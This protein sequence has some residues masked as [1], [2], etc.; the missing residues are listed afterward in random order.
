[1]V[2]MGNIWDR[3]AEFLSDNLGTVLPVALL[4]IFVPTVVSSNLSEL[5]QGAP[6]GLS[7][8]LG[9]ASLV[10]ALVTFWGQLTI[11]ALAIDPAQGRD[12]TRVATRR[13]LPALL[14]MIVLLGAALLTIIPLAII[15]AVGGMD[16]T[17]VQPGSMPE[18]PE[19]ARMPVAIYL[20]ILLPLSV[21]LFARLA[22]V[23]PVVVGEEKGVGAISR[24]WRLTRGM[25]LKIVGV[26]ILYVIVSLVATLAATTAFGT[27]MGL[28]AGRGD[29][30]ISLATVLTTIVGGVVSTGF[31]VLA[32]A[33][34]AKLF[35]ALSDR[36]AATRFELVQT[37]DATPQ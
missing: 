18:V 21:W 5:Q 20:L 22:V 32:A 35:V 28:I 3:T 25:A 37:E 11:T 7:I 27:I 17:A 12:A 29:G 30:G 10:L 36:Y 8:G 33:F 16:F 13:Y 6:P 31:T 4:A 24:S 1:M 9:A 19:S 14:V 34:T 23:L 15:L 2:S 26:L